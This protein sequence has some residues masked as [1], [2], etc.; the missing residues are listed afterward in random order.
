MGGKKR[1]QEVSDI[2]LR[3]PVILLAAIF[4]NPKRK[5]RLC[6]YIYMY[7]YIIYRYVHRVHIYN[8]NENS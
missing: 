2:R 3:A 7:I 4:R 8:I 1:K 5:K 6:V